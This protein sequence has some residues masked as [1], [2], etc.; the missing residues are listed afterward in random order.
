MTSIIQV[1]TQPLTLRRLPPLVVVA[2]QGAAG[3][4]R[5]MEHGNQWKK[6]GALRYTFEERFWSHVD[7][8][9]PNECWLW[10][11]GKTVGYGVIQINGKQEYAHRIAWTLANGTVPP[12][13]FI[14]HHCDTR[15]CCNP[16]HLFAG[17]QDDNMADMRAKGRDRL[18]Y[19]ENPPYGETNG[20][21]RLNWPQVRAA[22]TIYATGRVTIADVA[23]ILGVD[24]ST[25][26]DALHGETWRET[27]RTL[28]RI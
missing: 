6:N 17:T 5:A 19:R 26:A 2:P 16:G 7:R 18:N 10:T 12:G 1:K 25:M 22:R 28:E 15:S 13:L 8:R 23:C 27:D 4:E 24:R 3:L 11:T 20:N 21:A 9:G 14:C